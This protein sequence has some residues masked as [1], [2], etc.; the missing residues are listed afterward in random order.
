[1]R[2]PSVEQGCG[3]YSPWRYVRQ[4]YVPQSYKKY[5]RMELRPT[6]QPRRRVA[7]PL[8]TEGLS[9]AAPPLGRQPQRA[10]VAH[11]RQPA[12]LEAAAAELG[13]DVARDVTAPLAPVEAGPAI[14]AAARALRRQ[15]G[16]AAGEQAGG[17]G[18]E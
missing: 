15:R 17:R 18:G 3:E 13:A 8:H 9:Q 16:A 2:A 4:A 12:A 14:D 11:P 5:L 7:G 6:K 1:M 10:S